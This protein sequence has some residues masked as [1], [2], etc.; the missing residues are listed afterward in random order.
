LRWGD[1]LIDGDLLDGFFFLEGF[2]CHTG[3]EFGGQV[4][5][6][7]LYSWSIFGVDTPSRPAHFINMVLASFGG[8]TS[9]EKVCFRIAGL[10]SV[11]AEFGGN[12]RG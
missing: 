7:V 4:S 2:K 9:L 12:R 10:G 8:A 5:F 6:F 11:G 1:I 3:F